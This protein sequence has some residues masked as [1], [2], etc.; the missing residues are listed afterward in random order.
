MYLYVHRI[1]L[2]R[3]LGFE[4]KRR[5]YALQKMEKIYQ[6]ITMQYRVSLAFLFVKTA[7][8]YSGEIRSPD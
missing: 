4:G 8:P 2:L 1:E 3:A 7:F 6:I 5:I